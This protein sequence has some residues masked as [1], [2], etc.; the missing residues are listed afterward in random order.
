MNSG[1]RSNA[2]GN[3]RV[4]RLLS[5]A[6]V[7]LLMSCGVL[8]INILLHNLFPD[9]HTTL[10]AGMVL[11]VVIDRLYTYRQLKSLTPLSTEWVIALGAQWIVILLVVRLLLSYSNGIEALRK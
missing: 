4:F 10:I 11:F 9:W 8:T 5:Y 7:F 6:L 3:E 1:A 2:I